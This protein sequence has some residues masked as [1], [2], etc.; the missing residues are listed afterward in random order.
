MTAQNVLL[1]TLGHCLWAIERRE[2]PEVIGWCGIKLGP[3]R[4][5]TA[6]LP[7]LG[8]TLDLGWQGQGVATEAANAVVT[9]AWAQTAYPRLHAITTPANA[10]SRAVMV[11]LGMHRIA[12]D[13]FDHPALPDGDSLRRHVSYTIGRP[14]ARPPGNVRTSAAAR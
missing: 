1:E 4:T 14:P 11:R 5:P 2:S 7:E 3:D 10:A 13:D 12:G 9:W 6:G 8:W